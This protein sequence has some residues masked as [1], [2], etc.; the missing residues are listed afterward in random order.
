MNQ[1]FICVNPFFMMRSGEKQKNQF[2]QFVHI[3]TLCAGFQASHS[4]ARVSL[5]WLSINC[6]A[7]QKIQW[8][9]DLDLLLDHL[10][11]EKVNY[12]LLNKLTR[13]QLHHFLLHCDLFSSSLVCCLF[14]C[15]LVSLERRRC[16]K[17]FP[18]LSFN[19]RYL[20]LERKFPVCPAPS[21]RIV[22]TPEI[23]PRYVR[24]LSVSDVRVLFNHSAVLHSVT[25]HS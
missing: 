21:V 12:R 20:S 24:F 1:Q 15:K 13:V 16:W 25:S 6:S 9:R 18:L 7:V 23:P 4:P 10:N 19:R 17:I 5:Y 14:S 22:F 8:T 11:K 3:L 2:V